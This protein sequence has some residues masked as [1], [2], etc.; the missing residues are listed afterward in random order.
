MPTKILLTSIITNIA[1][2]LL[3]VVGG[4]LSGS[5]GLVADGFHSITDVVAMS[6]NYAGIRISLSPAGDLEA[7]ENYKKEIVGTFAVSFALFVIGLFILARSYLKLTKGIT[8]SP[9]LGAGLIIVVAF[10]ITCWLYFYVKKE[11]KGSNSPGLEINTEQI[12]LNVFSTVAVLVGIVGSC[13]DM[14]YLDATAAIFVSLIILYSSIV[15]ILKFFR[16]I[17]RARLSPLQ[18]DEI[19][20][21]VVESS[22][23]LCVARI[24]TMVIRKKIWLF[25]EVAAAPD[26]HSLNRLKASLLSNLRYLENVIIRPVPAQTTRT[27]RVEIE[28]FGRELRAARNYL[29]LT[30]VVSLVFLVSASAFGFSFLSREHH[31]LIPA[32]V[33]DVNGRVSGQLSTA[34]YFYLYRIDREKGQF[35]EKR[36]AFGQGDIDSKIAKLFKDYCVEAVVARKVGPRL[37]EELNSAGI[38]LYRAESNGP[39]HQQIQRFRQGQLTRLTKPNIDIEFGLD[40]LRMLEPWHNWR[41]L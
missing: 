8:Q 1:L 25:L 17:E 15:I 38:A 32:D 19:T 26:P 41:S 24:K 28:D 7:C 13:F 9:G 37:F 12:K 34:P 20:S 5:A 35:I 21:L 6:V 11:S 39:L 29:S 31:V 10:V 3:K 16:E 33:A 4:L 27:L 2:S 18:I 22:G 23:I 36:L 30:V 40:N 14:N